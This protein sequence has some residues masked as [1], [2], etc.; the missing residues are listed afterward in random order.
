MVEGSISED[1]IVA[2][3]IKKRTMRVVST[4][5]YQR[6][7]ENKKEDE[8]LDESL[9][10]ILDEFRG[11]VL[12]Q[13][14]QSTESLNSCDKALSLNPNYAQA[15]VF[16]GN[17]LLGLGRNSEAIASC[18]KA[19]AINTDDGQAWFVRGCAQLLLEQPEKALESFDNAIAKNPDNAEARKYREGALNLINNEK[20]QNRSIKDKKLIAYAPP[21]YEKVIGA[22]MTIGAWM[23][24][25]AFLIVA[26]LV[27]MLVLLTI[28]GLTL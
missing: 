16:R 4:K 7:L 6:I 26:G 12:G 11:Y 1:E 20:Q 2:A 23:Y 3:V 10:R 24:Y 14:G 13:L 27:I 15:W 28:Y 19:L 22:S 25:I 9:K 8:T 18:D 17:T 5:N 21:Y